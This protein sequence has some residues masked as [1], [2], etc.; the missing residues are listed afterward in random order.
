MDFVINIISSNTLF[1]HIIMDNYIKLT[2]LLQVADD[3][4]DAEDENGNVELKGKEGEDDKEREDEGEEDPFAD[5]DVF[6]AMNVSGE[7]VCL[8]F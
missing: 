5:N 4:D 7:L 2:K 1:F 3:G 6:T 8:N